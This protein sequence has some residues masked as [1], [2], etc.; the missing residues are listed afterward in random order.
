MGIGET[1]IFQKKI[2]IFIRVCMLGSN[3]N[4]VSVMAIA[5]QRRLKEKN[6][7]MGF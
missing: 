3:Y 2:L 1:L 5:D 4:Y 7:I 6:G